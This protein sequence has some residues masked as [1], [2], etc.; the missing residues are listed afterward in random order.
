MKKYIIALILIIIVA[1][2]M[3]FYWQQN[4]P[5]LFTEPAQ[6]AC[7]EEAKICPDGSTVVRQGP[8]CE[9]AECPTPAVSA[10]PVAQ[11]IDETADWKTYRNEK[12]G[13]EFK[14]PKDIIFSSPVSGP[15]SLFAI[16]SWTNQ[17]VNKNKLAVGLFISLLDKSGEDM[18][19]EVGGDWAET[20]Q[21]HELQEIEIGG[22]PAIKISNVM[23]TVSDVG[24]GV[25]RTA[26]VVIHAFKNKNSYSLQCS[27]DGNDL[28]KCDQIIS[29]FKFTEETITAKVGQEFIL[30]P[31]ASF[32]APYDVSDSVDSYTAYHIVWGDGTPDLV[33]ACVKTPMFGHTY[34]NSG[35]FTLKYTLSKRKVCS[36]PASSFGPVVEKSFT[37]VVE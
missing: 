25:S 12:Y 15:R 6:M 11:V 2:G 19:K 29:T 1:G 10:E 3:F 7:T 27:Q 36:D 24:G 35:T 34:Q 20:E 16:D 37:I 31:S 8:G 23:E 4:R 13:F 18:L 9:F 14:Y 21:P 28:S 26:T 17:E 5:F 22:N 32:P 33:D 30:N